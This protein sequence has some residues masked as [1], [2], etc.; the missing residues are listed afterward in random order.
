MKRLG[1]TLLWAC[2][3]SLTLSAQLPMHIVLLGDSNTFLGGDACDQPQGWNKWFKDLATPL[4]C[5]SY[6][7]SGATWTHTDKTV[8]DVEEYT[9]VLSDN[10]VIYNQV[11]RLKEAVENGTQVLPDLILIMAGTN[12]LW[13][14]DKRPE[15]LEKYVTLNLDTLTSAFPQARIILVTPPPFTKVPMWQQHQAA[16]E[17]ARCAKG[18]RQAVIR[19]DQKGPLLPADKLIR[20]GYSKDGVHTTVKGAKVLGQYIYEQTRLITQP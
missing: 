5:Y 10:N 15:P 16:D 9:G 11:N 4:S 6:A 2:L 14:K 8:Y 20:R 3:L 7:R 12:D 1:L 18:E 19:L 13:F 17:I